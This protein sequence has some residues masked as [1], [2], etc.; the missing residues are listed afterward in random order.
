L[1]C[2]AEQRTKESKPTTCHTAGIPAKLVPQVKVCVAT[3][4]CLDLWCLPVG[5]L[6]GRKK[7]GYLCAAKK[8]K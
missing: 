8:E 6:P 3:E 4:G 5:F 7:G 1:W 2:F